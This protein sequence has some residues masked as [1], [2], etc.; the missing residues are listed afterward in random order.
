MGSVLILIT[1]YDSVLSNR[2]CAMLDFQI[3]KMTK[4]NCNLDKPRSLKPESVNMKR[5]ECFCV[6]VI[7]IV[8]VVLLQLLKKQDSSFSHRAHAL[9]RR[10]LTHAAL[11]E[12]V[13]HA[14]YIWQSS[15]QVV[16]DFPN[17]G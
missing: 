17:W 9:L 6:C 14:S 12:H 16:P 11:F 7:C 15:H 2:T 8:R 5:L 4:F 3:N 1:P 13:L 10:Y